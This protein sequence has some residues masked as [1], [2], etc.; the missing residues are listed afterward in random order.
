MIWL[1]G[2]LVVGSIFASAMVFSGDRSH[3]LIGKTTSG[4]HQIELACNA[5]HTEGFSNVD[6][7]QKACLKCHESE[8]KVSNDS[9]PIKKFRDPRNADRLQKL[10]AT[11]CVTCHTEHRPGITGEM[12]LTI[13]KDYCFKCHAKIGE[14][15][16]INHKNLDF[17]SCASA[18]CHNYH[19]NRALY[20]DYLEKHASEPDM[21][22]EQLVKNVNQALLSEEEGGP[23]RG[24]ALA[25]E[26]ADGA[27]EKTIENKVVLDEWHMDAHGRNGVNCSGCHSAQEAGD[28][29]AKVSWIKK[30]GRAECARCHVQ[31]NKSFLRGK[32]G[33]RL[34]EGLKVSEDG[35]FGLIKEK[36]LSPMKPELARLPM[37]SEAHGRELS[38]TTC[39]GVKDKPADR[40]SLK[41]AHQFNV[42]TAAVEACVSCHDD[43]HS[44]AYVASPHYKLWKKEVAGELPKGSGVSCAT[45]H[46]PRMSVLDEYE[47]EVIILNHNQNENLR[48]N[49]KMVRSVCLSCHGLSFSIDA[50]ADKDLISKNFTGRPG[51][52]IKSIDWTVERAKKLEA[53]KK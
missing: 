40:A 18:G 48:P 34:T 32:H 16:P 5:C 19:D 3:L 45:C 14:D 23:K 1:L 30:P 38:C 49:E 29:K 8:L 47:N 20:E 21:K 52:H 17:A 53:Q 36:K 11:K 35:L 2:T 6:T 15:R 4:H 10:E 42:K 39:H 44:K 27:G 41:G 43:K 46:M 12:G 24:E 9:H 13:P 7:I 26:Q 50:L 22:L 33:M 51:V 31:E 37:K 28:D 25:P